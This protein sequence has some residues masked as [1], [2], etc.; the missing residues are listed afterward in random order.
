M[1]EYTPPSIKG[2]HVVLTGPIVG[3]VTLP[4]GSKVDV[5]PAVISVDSEEK[6]AEVAHAIGKHWAEPANIHPGQI[7]HDPDT[8]ETRVLDFVYDDSHYKST[9]KRLKAGKGR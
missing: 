6:A 5:T 1:S 2:E 3:D 8:G 9:I 7:D 4:D